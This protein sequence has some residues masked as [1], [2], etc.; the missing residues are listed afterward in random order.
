MKKLLIIP[1]LAALTSPLIVNTVIAENNLAQNLSGKIL[2]QVESV[3]EAWYV[4][5]DNLKKYYMG[6]PNDAFD[7]MRN[8]GLGIKHEELSGYLNSNFPLRLTGKIML[9]VEKNGE[10]YYIYPNDLKGY[11]LGRPSDAFNIMK[12]LSLGITNNNLNKIISGSLSEATLPSAPTPIP[13]PQL[14][15][16]NVIYS[17][18][19]AIRS[20]DI[21]KSL[22]FFTPGLYKAVEYSLNTLNDDSKLMFA[23]IFSSSKLFSSTENEKIYSNKVYFGLGGY[24]VEINFYVTKQED[25][26]WLI[27]RI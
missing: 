1:V 15:D 10:A 22:T 6:R 14:A 13:T 9:D 19:N 25:G 3:G 18:A 4:S 27:S 26:T 7:L 23:N 24:E 12:N 20:N 11:Y 21:D 16:E 8:L 2:L 5:P 17:A